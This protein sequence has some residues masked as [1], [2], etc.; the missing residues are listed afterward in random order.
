[1]ISITELANKIAKETNVAIFCHVRPDGDA[2]GSALAL[3]LALKSLGANADVFCDDVVP[4][5]F[6][7]LNQATTVRRDFSLSDNYSALIAIDCG[8][9]NRLG[10][11]AL[12]FDGFK[13]TYSIDHHISN[14]RFAKINY[15]VDNASNC[16]NAY[17][18]ITQ[19]G[20]NITKEIADL[21]ALGVVTDTGNFKHNNVN[22]NTFSVASALASKGADFNNI[23]YN[24]F[25]KQSKERATL[26][27]R[28]MS[29]I[30][31]M[32]GD[33]FAFISI[34]QDDLISAG[35]KPDETEG[36]IDFIMGIDVVE[37]GA[38]IMETAKNKFKISLRSKNL[39]VNAVAGSFGGGGHTHAS[40]CQLFGEYEEVVDRLSFAV[41][42]ELP[43]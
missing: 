14:T 22:A 41:S 31:Y 28:I 8:E 37:I 32:H 40:G 16:E 33:R 30:R 26:F 12:S 11:F 13:N 29:K 25:T 34:F 3:K 42:R 27:G 10:D 5:R 23:V 17:E 24:T 35:A 9:L 43:E 19:M 18:L 1:M 36:F 21:L 2:L 15:V 38:S 39:D 20:V 6:S 4:L 7:F